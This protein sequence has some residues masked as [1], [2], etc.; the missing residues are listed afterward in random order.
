MAKNVV[1]LDNLVSAMDK[2]I[3]EK[4]EAKNVVS[5]EGLLEA[6]EKEHSGPELNKRKDT[7][8]IRMWFNGKR[9]GGLVQRPILPVPL[10]QSI[11]P[12]VP[13]VSI[14]S[15]YVR[16]DEPV[17][18]ELEDPTGFTLFLAPSDHAIATFST[19]VGLKPWEFPELV[20][21]DATDDAVI[22]RNI[23]AFVKAHMS[24]DDPRIME[25][26]ALSGVL[27]NNKPFKITKLEVTETYTLEIQGIEIA[28][29][30]VH[31]AGNGI[32]FVVEKVLV[33]GKGN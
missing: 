33:D 3:A 14:F 12:Q 17:I 8:D 16:D 20:K 32:V 6:L 29:S 5:L 13:Q 10:L 11:L 1:Y 26:N 7:Q 22:G 9:D 15:R 19:S 27:L 28:V 18:S 21:N 2:G 24:N 23:D 31:S 4:R 30:S 25:D